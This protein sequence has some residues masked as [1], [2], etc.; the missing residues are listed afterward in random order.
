[1]GSLTPLLEAQHVARAFHGVPAVRDGNIR[2]E[3][4]SIHA[5]CGGNGAGKSTLINMLTGILQPDAGQILRNGEPVRYTSPRHALSDGISLISQE[6]TTIFDMTVAENIF[7]GRELRRGRIGVNHKQQNEE[8]EALLKRLGFPISPT[9]TMATLSLAEMQLVEIAKAI[10]RD[11]QVLIMDEPTSALGEA[12]AERL[13]TAVEALRDHDVG[14]VYVSHRLSDLFRICDS[15]T[16]MRDGTFIE[17]GA[18]EEIDRHRLVTLIVGEELDEQKRPEPLPSQEPLLSV[19]GF[20]RADAFGEISLDLHRGEVLGIYG[21]MGSGRSEFVSALYGL[22]KADQGQLLVE[23]RELTINGP[24]DALA[25]GLAFATEDRKVTGLVLT[26]SVGHNISITSLS[27]LASL[28]FIDQGKERHLID[29]ATARFGIKAASSAIDV[30]HLSG[31]NQQ[32]VVLARCMA[33]QPKVL[34]CDEP[35]RGIDEGAKR[36]IYAFFQE[37]VAQGCAVLMVSSEIHEVIENCHR[38]I[39]FNQGQIADVLSSETVAQT[40]LVHLAS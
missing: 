2:I 14:I 22:D 25:A 33:T 3:S 4:G 29:Q 9:Q 31:G 39:V 8:A 17:A 11:M 6:L 32:K 12:E 38:I 35:T 10:G 7:L 21:L 18:M 24:A 16:V 36:Q 23:G 19:R 40:S 13:F 26:S 37:F 27:D 30:A 5:L 34:I 28:G 1:M 15:Y 20:G